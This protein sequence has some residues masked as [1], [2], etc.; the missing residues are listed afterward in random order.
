MKSLLKYHREQ[1]KATLA[2]LTAM[3]DPKKAIESF[4]DA[5]IEQSV[6]DEELKGC[7][8]MNTALDLPNQDADVSDTVKTGM[9]EAES[10]FHSQIIIGQSRGEF[11]D[12]LDPDSVAKG[13]LTLVAGLRV[14]ARGTYDEE[15]L[16]AIKTQALAM[17]S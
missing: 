7:L 12:H 15:S 3:D 6:S 17:V 14:L 8:L 16:K 1:H 2:R 4:F 13:L 10:F 9:N 5:L 11:P